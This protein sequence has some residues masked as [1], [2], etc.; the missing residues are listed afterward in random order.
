MPLP[1]IDLNASPQL[2]VVRPATTS[3]SVCMVKATGR[4]PPAAARIASSLR[5]RGAEW[6]QSVSSAS[7]LVVIKAE[8]QRHDGQALGI[9]IGHFDDVASG[10]NRGDP[11]GIGHL[12]IRTAHH[13]MLAGDRVLILT[14]DGLA[15][16]RDILHAHA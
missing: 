1:T 11:L 4:R 6:N 7:R 9:R 2:H 13:A 16:A 12:A 15:S 14:L 10:D 3:Q 8:I 5:P